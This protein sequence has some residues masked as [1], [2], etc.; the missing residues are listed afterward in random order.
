[1]AFKTGSY[2]NLLETPDDKE[3]YGMTVKCDE[4]YKN[5]PECY[6]QVLWSS[7]RYNNKRKERVLN[8]WVHF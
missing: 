6:A 5:G 1:M 7:E 8:S 4:L 3:L 2:R